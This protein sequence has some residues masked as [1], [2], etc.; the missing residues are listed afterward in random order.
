[1]WAFAKRIL[2]RSQT[3]NRILGE[4]VLETSIVQGAS[5]HSSFQWRIKKSAVGGEYFVALKMRPD[6]YAGAEGSPTNY[7]SFDIEAA[8]QLKFDLEL[9]IDECRRLS[10]AVSAQSASE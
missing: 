3:F 1:M 2:A 5:S 9:C 4:V 6:S 8:E 7:M 10:G